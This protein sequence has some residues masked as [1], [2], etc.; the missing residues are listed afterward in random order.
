[1]KKILAVLI[2]IFTL[3]T[4]SQ[5]DDIRDFQIEGMS[6]GD[7]ALDYFSEAKIKSNKKNWYKN[8]EVIGVEIEIASVQYDTVQIHYR[9][10]DKTYKMIG[11]NGLKFYNNNVE[12]CYKQQNKI[13]KELKEFFPN[14]NPTNQKKN[15]SADK[16]GESKIKF[17]SF[18]LK[19]KDIVS[20]ACY[21]WSKKMKYWDHLRIGLVSFE[22]ND[23]LKIAYK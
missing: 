9:K 10:N 17:K 8:K 11:I 21:D 20:T 23:W 7:S 2:L 22:L 14:I 3:P 5:A 4:P 6:I 1:M 18:H 19:S 16:S 12:E 13:V 15:H